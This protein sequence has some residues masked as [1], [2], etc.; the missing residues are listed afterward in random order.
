MYK[1]NYILEEIVTYPIDGI[2]L[3]HQS[4]RAN[5]MTE[6]L[7]ISKRFNLVVTG[8]SDFHRLNWHGE[9]LLGEY[10]INHDRW[11]DLKHYLIEKGT[12]IAKNVFNR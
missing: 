6:I 10:G 4:N 5:M 8:G 2:E 1:N 3:Y 9:N 11:I 12:F 7:N